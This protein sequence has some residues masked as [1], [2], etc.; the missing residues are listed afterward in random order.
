MTP[1][2]ATVDLAAQENTKIAFSHPV[3]IPQQIFR[4]YDIRG[5]AYE[6]LSPEL[7]YSIGLAIGTEALLKK[8]NNIVLGRDGRLS[9]PELSQA[10]IQG[11]L[12]TGIDVL[13]AGLVPTPVLYF[14]IATLKTHSGVMLTASHN[15]KEYNGLK[16]V[17][18]E[19]TLAED[20][21]QQIYQRVCNQDYLKGKGQYQTVSVLEGYVKDIVQHIKLSRS[22]KIV[23]DCGNGITGM[24]APQLFK[25]LGCEVIAL[26][27]EVDGHFPNHHPD[28][29]DLSNLKTLIETV[30]KEKADIGFAFDGDGDRCGVI[31][32]QGENVW[33]DRQMMLFA[34][35]L[36]ER[37]PGAEI[38]FD[39][40]CTRYLP[41]I[42]KKYGGKPLMWKTGHSLLKNKMRERGALLAGEMSGHVFFKERWYGF[43]D[44]LYTACRL[45][46]ILSKDQRSSSEVFA[47]LPDS[48]NTPELKL[49]IPEEEKFLFMEQLIQHFN[50]ENA[51]KSTI[52]GLRVE[53][54]DGWGLIRPSNTTPYLIL[55]FEADTQTGLEGIQAIFRDQLLALDS[56]LKLPF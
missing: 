9:G 14:A 47:S 40:K 35:D 30:K 50:V 4:A 22:M 46:E 8:Q 20:R 41:E 24:I 11:L 23:I 15:P 43:D 5:I 42:I 44:G 29:S 28:P 52:D 36:L 21:I 54:E 7:V 10:L 49:A 34:M 53:F 37:Q 16:T 26:F 27:D 18:N 12:D 55:R 3:H 48:V 33:A 38:L 56:S 19:E 45:L 31:T 39:V 32:N 2:E 51:T 13:D 6:A 25:A 17:I 1:K